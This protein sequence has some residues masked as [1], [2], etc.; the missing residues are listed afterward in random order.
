MSNIPMVINSA[1]AGIILISLIVVPLLIVFVL[2]KYWYPK[3]I[4][5]IENKKENIDDK[6]F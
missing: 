4:E 5:S 2:N 3:L 1:L 6:E